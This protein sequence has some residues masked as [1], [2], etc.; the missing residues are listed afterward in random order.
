MMDLQSNCPEL[1][2][3]GKKMAMAFAEGYA[4]LIPDEQPRWLVAGQSQLTP[5]RK[6]AVSTKRAK[7]INLAE[8]G[9]RGEDGESG[10]SNTGADYAR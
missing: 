7:R 2:Q 10:R 8:F 5:L 9:N 6:Q 3:S 1:V 4:S